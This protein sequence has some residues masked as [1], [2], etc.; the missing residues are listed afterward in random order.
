MDIQSTFSNI[1]LDTFKLILFHLKP[2][3]NFE[4]FDKVHSK[5]LHGKLYYL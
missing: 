3:E 5:R 2:H 1:H 4:I